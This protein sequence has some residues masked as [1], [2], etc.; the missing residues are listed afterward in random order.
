MIFHQLIL[1]WVFFLLF[2]KIWYTAI[3][4][5]FLALIPKHVSPLETAFNAY[6]IYN[7]FPLEE[8]VVNENSPIFNIIEIILLSLNQ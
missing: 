7:N 6:S 5:P 1:N 8:K 4:T 2:K 3:T